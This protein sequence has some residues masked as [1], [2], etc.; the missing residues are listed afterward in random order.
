MKSK[1]EKVGFAVRLVPYFIE[2]GEVTSAKTGSESGLYPIFAVFTEKMQTTD[3]T[4]T[5]GVCERYSHRGG[6]PESSADVLF[7]LYY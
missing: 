2:C 3:D 1:I 5:E 7:S 4:D 6:R